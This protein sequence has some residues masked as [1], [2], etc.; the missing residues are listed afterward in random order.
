MR[1]LDRQIATQSYERTLLSHDKSAMLQ[2]A[3]PAMAEVT[4]V[5]DIRNPF[6]LEFLDLKDEYSESDFEE[7][8][9]K[10]TMPLAACRTRS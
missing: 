3:A 2:Q 6:I 4:P 1:Q 5:Q 10:H 7:A 9:V 8:L